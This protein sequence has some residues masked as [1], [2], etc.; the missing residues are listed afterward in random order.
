VLNLLLALLIAPPTVASHAP[1]LSPADVRA[2]ESAVVEELAPESGRL[3]ARPTKDR[4]LL[5]DQGQ[6]SSVM[7]KLMTEPLGAFNIPRSFRVTGRD[8]AVQCARAPRNECKVV[9]DG[10]YVT[11]TDADFV[12]ARGEVRVHA[13]VL[14]THSGASGNELN[15]YDVDLFLFRTASGWRIARRGSFRVG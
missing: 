13:A 1:A 9:N 3:G 8:S 10:I 14:W 2:I 7:Q 15:G 5:I 12:P 4:V 6:V 11:I